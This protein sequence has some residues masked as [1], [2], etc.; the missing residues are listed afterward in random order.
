MENKIGV[1]VG[2]ALLIPSL[3]IIILLCF[4]QAELL[5]L[6]VFGLQAIVL[7]A[8]LILLFYAEYYFNHDDFKKIRNS[9]KQYIRDCNLLNEHIID[10]RNA[11]ISVHKT[12]YGR[13]NYRSFDKY[14]YRRPELINIQEEPN[15]I[16]CSRTV[17]TNAKLNPPKYFCKYFNI[18]EDEESLSLFESILS[19]YM[20]ANEGIALLKKQKSTIIRTAKK[21]IPWVITEFF[22]RRLSEELGFVDYTF[23]D[24]YYHTYYYRYIS[25]GGYASII[26]EYILDIPNLEIL[27][28]Y[29]AERIRYRNSA[30]GQRRLMT[31][32]LR[33]SILKRDNYTCQ[34]PLCNNSM[35]KE[36]NLLLE[37]D[38][39]VPIS[40]GGKTTEDNLQTL[41]WR[42]N[43]K[44]GSKLI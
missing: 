10:L 23:D 26:T 16:N 20:A 18:K 21:D 24:I 14:N 19:N 33:K 41:C 35:W 1:I 37:I 39:I 11:F 34:N 28:Q 5:C 9:Q 13:A 3:I 8:V 32:S 15:I 27:T 44:K 6:V 29:L 7:L 43:R 38:H 22:S 25:S 40:K 4:D 2:C 30:I 42:C 36:K 12:D 17:C 31:P